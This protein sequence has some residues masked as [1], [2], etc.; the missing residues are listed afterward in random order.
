M[1]AYRLY[2]ISRKITQHSE[3]LENVNQRSLIWKCKSAGEN[4]MKCVCVSMNRIE[5]NLR[6]R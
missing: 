3:A 1:N 6:L 5:T 2:T 4:S